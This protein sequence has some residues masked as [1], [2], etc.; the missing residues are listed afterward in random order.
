MMHP[1]F[2]DTKKKAEAKK[3]VT[4]NNSAGSCL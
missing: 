3:A 4:E 1:A 2:D